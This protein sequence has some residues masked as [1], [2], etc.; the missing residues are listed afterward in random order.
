MRKTKLSKDGKKI[1][2]HTNPDTYKR[3]MN[4]MFL[5][6]KFRRKWIERQQQA[7]V[8]S[9]FMRYILG[10]Q[11]RVNEEYLAYLFD[12]CKDKIKDIK[13]FILLTLFNTHLEYHLQ[14]IHL[15]WMLFISNGYQ[16]T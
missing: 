16:L 2:Q 3:N 4:T 12:A 5:I 6:M 8:L 15:V 10:K 14:M 1:L 11:T 13:Y 9:Q 7:D